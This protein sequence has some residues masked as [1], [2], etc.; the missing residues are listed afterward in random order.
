MATGQNEIRP[1][2][3][4][5]ASK[6]LTSRQ[7]DPESSARTNQSPHRPFANAQRDS[8]TARI[9]TAAE[10]GPGER[11]LTREDI[12][13]DLF[14]A[15]EPM[16][17]PTIARQ[18]AMN[19]SVQSQQP[20]SR[21]L[22]PAILCAPD[23]G[24]PSMTSQMATKGN[25]TPV[26]PEEGRGSRMPS[27]TSNMTVKGSPNPRPQD[28]EPEHVMSPYTA[29]SVSTT[30]SNVKHIVAESKFHDETLCQLLDAARLN[31]IG[32]EAKKALNRAARARVIELR[33]MRAHGGVCY[34]VD[35][36]S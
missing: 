4:P 8:K 16:Y 7:Y 24:V 6:H 20:P 2:D 34:F 13:T 18:V 33:D 14:H 5:S 12:E 9:K 1:P 32:E 11:Q 25:L 35:T 19:H 3:A 30:P 26:G 36:P 28:L 10:A 21:L 23:T 29:S 22:S 17:G 31:L 27:M 15:L